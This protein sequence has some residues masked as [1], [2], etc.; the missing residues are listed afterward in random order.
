MPKPKNRKNKFRRRRH[1]DKD[2]LK[3]QRK[4]EAR[5]K[6]MIRTRRSKS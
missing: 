2:A 5:A 4:E 6:K 1:P 3:E